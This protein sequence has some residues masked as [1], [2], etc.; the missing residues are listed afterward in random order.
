MKHLK[1]GNALG[2][3]GTYAEML[4]AE[5]VAALLWLH[6][7][8]YTIPNMGIVAADWRF[9]LDLEEKRVTPTSVTTGAGYTPLCI[10]HGSGTNPPLSCPQKLLAHQ[11]YKQSGLKHKKST[12]KSTTQYRDV[13][14]GILAKISMRNNESVGTARNT[15]LD[16]ADD[17]AVFQETNS[18]GSTLSA[19]RESRTA[20]KPSFL[21]QRS[22]SRCSETFWMGPPSRFL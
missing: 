6:T 15:H 9:C 5:E 7:V 13:L 14:W 22:R 18:F 3:C 4:K 19:E 2:W 8:L 17:A 1:W 21:D 20:G 11:S 12:I 10:R 16:V